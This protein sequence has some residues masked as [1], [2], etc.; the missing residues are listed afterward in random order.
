[1]SIVHLPAHDFPDVDQIERGDSESEDSKDLEEEETWDD[2][3]SDPVSMEQKCKSLFDDSVLPSA[4]QAVEHDKN[5][6]GFDLNDVCHRLS[7]DFLKRTRLINFIRKTNPSP[8]SLKALVGSEDLFTSDE[9]LV[10]VLE[11]DPLLLLQMDDWS[12]S[13]DEKDSSDPQK[14][15]RILEQQLAQTNAELAE[16]R[17]LLSRTLDVSDEPTSAEVN[18]APTTDDDTNYFQSYAENDIHAIMIQDSVRTSSYARFISHNVDLFIDAVVL[19]VGCGTGILSLFAVRSGAKRVYAVDASDIAVKAAEIVR[20]NKYDDVIT[21]VR[22]KIED[23]DIPEKVDIIISEWMGY[24]LLYESMLD[25]VLRARDRFL[26]P[27]GIMAPS[28]CRMMLGLSD[29]GDVWKNRFAFWADV[30]GFDL[31]AM[32][33]RLYEEAVVDVVGADALLSPPCAVKDLYLST[34]RSRDLD[35]VA[36]FTLVSN[37]DRRSRVRCF[38]LYFD[39]FF[40]STGAPVPAD[41]PVAIVKRGDPVTAEVWPLGGRREAGKAVKPDVV[42]AEPESI[43]EIVSFSTGPESIPTH[44]KQTLFFLREPIVV[45][46]GTTVTGSFHCRKSSTN[47]RELDVEIHYTIKDSVDAPITNDVVVQMFKIR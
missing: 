25:S 6:H 29:G 44:W 39:T 15:V 42:H 31:S 18:L 9:Y 28:Q 7:L 17:S 26:R 24:A 37:S 41:E 32:A 2:W 23:I 35:F 47:A 14:R 16:C 27:G 20:A 22:G 1:M 46:E 10:P 33:D 36:P 3:I 43:R 21:V 45:E 8:N 34:V 19:D 40:D 5:V 11:D 12:D 13:E 4:A 30:Y 38:V